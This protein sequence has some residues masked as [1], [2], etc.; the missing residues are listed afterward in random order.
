MS[1]KIDGGLF[2]YD[3]IDHHAILCVPVDADAKEVRKRY[4]KIARRLHPD[5]SVV[6]KSADKDIA[7]QL[8]SK[9]VN[10]A[11]E[12]LSVERNR[13][14]YSLILS[15]IG[16]RLAQESTSIELSTDIAKQLAIAPNI[17]LL[18]KSEVAKLAE[19]QF[20]EL[21]QVSQFISQISELNLVY[22]MRRAGRLMKT[23]QSLPTNTTSN[24]NTPAS[25][26]PPPPKDDSP[27]AQYLRRAQIL[28]EK[29]QFTQA[30][31]ELQDALKLEPRNSRC[32]SLMAIIYLQQNQLKM[33]KIHFENAL[34]LN[35]Q[36]KIALEWKPK[37]EQAMGIKSGTVQVDSSPNTGDN[38]P[39]NSGN[40]GLFGGLFGGK[41]K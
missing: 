14:E 26:P 12:K 35:P 23:P 8:L 39:D 1:L 4:L 2:K 25:P 15:Q 19:T 31:V 5:S 34:R 40:G 3:F 17:D 36:D 13:A 18:Y 33:A 32:H 22:L 27:V 38:Q 6:T 7:N 20:D 16:K 29:N 41:K 24:T 21:Q 30:K 11:Y 10:P 28:I 9:L 37:V